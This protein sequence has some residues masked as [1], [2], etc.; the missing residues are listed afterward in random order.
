MFTLTLI[1]SI[2]SEGKEFR[3]FWWSFAGDTLF[4]VSALNLEGDG[5][6][7]GNGD[8]LEVWRLD[9]DCD[10]GEELT[11]D[12]DAGIDKGDGGIE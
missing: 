5:P 6:G 7:E 9:V 2:I 8:D 3:I 11:Q 4:G 10:K 1:L 12:G